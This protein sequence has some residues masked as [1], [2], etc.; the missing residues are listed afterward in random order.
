MVGKCTFMNQYYTSIYSQNSPQYVEDQNV[1]MFR[2]KGSL[3]I[4][5]V[6]RG[7]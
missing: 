2:L 5:K 3:I 6:S 1:K 7:I 4:G